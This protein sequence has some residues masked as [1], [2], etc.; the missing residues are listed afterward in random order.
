MSFSSR[1]YTSSL[2]STAKSTWMMSEQRA[3][4]NEHKDMLLSKKKAK[5]NQGNSGIKTTLTPSKQLLLFTLDL[6]C[7]R[8]K[9]GLFSWQKALLLPVTARH[10]RE[11]SI[12]NQALHN[13]PYSIWC[14]EETWSR[15]KF[16]LVSNTI[17][18]S[19][20]DLKRV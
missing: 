1:L 7:Q 13:G 8:P 11:V 5:K 19:N 4:K 2:G 15:I 12:S 17:Y 20:T 18:T 3:R 14:P 16:L 9:Q 10:T 6:H